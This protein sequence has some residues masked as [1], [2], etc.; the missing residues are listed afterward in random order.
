ME[1][2]NHACIDTVAGR[3]WIDLTPFDVSFGL[4]GGGAKPKTSGRE[5]W[6]RRQ[7]ARTVEVEAKTGGFKVKHRHSEGENGQNEG[8]NGEN[9]KEIC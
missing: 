7:D 3:H 1:A 9:Q 8:N 4:Q 6:E 5:R 2:E